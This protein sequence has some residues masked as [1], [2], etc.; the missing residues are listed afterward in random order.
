MKEISCHFGKV[1]ITSSIQHTLRSNDY[2][3]VIFLFEMFSETDENRAR[4]TILIV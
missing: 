3:S 4:V 1:Y 2:I